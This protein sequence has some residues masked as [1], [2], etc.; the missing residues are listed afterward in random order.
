MDQRSVEFAQSRS[1]LLRPSSS[2]QFHC[3]AP[4]NSCDPFPSCS[5]AW[6]LRWHKGKCPREALQEFSVFVFWFEI[7]E[8]WAFPCCGTELT[9]GAGRC[10]H[11]PGTELFLLGDEVG[12]VLVPSRALGLSAGCGRLQFPSN[13]SSCNPGLV[14][15]VMG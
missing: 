15:L 6:S 11:S 14:S 8:L 13:F 2:E 4:M 9:A 10:C 5:T 12:R 3:T 7:P 1:A